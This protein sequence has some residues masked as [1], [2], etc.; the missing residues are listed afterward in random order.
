MG[1]W[2]ALCSVA[3]IGL[4]EAWASQTPTPPPVPLPPGV[5]MRLEVKD[6]KTT[7]KMGEPIDLEL[8]ISGDNQGYEV[9]AWDGDHIVL[10]PEANV[11]RWQGLF[12]SDAV[13]ASALTAQGTTFT[14]RLNDQF[15]IKDPGTYTALVHTWRVMKKPETPTGMLQSME[16][17][18]NTVTF[19]VLP[20]SEADEA[21]RVKMLAAQIEAAA[22]PE[23]AKKAWDEL[24]YLTGDA[25]AHEKVRLALAARNGELAEFPAPDQ[26]KSRIGNEDM[27]FAL[28]KNKQLEIELLHA[29]WLDARNV[30]DQGLL[31]SMTA[32]ARLDA[33]IGMPDTCG[34]CAMPRTKWDDTQALEKP[35]IDE[36]VASM[37]QRTGENRKET[38]LFLYQKLSRSPAS[39]GFEEARRIVIENFENYSVDEQQALMEFDIWQPNNPASLYDPSLIPVLVRIFKTA[40][41][42]EQDTDGI[43]SERHQRA[44]IRL[45]EIAPEVAV[46]YFVEE[47]KDPDAE[48]DLRQFGGLKETTLPQ[49]D[50]VLLGQIQTFAAEA[51]KEPGTNVKANREV[52]QAQTSLQDRTLLAAR[53][54]SSSI[55]AP[56]LELYRQYSAKWDS[57]QRGAVL[58]FLLRWDAAKT[59]PLLR[60]AVAPDDPPYSGTVAT[61][62]QV[63]SY[64][65]KPFPPEL[66][67]DLVEKVAHGSYEEVVSAAIQ[68][69]LHGLPEDEA[70]LKKRLAAIQAELK[71]HPERLDDSPN[72]GNA[73]GLV[74][75]ESALIGALR[76]DQVWHPTESDLIGLKQD[77]LGAFCRQLTT[78]KAQPA[79]PGY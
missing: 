23:V 64:I 34:M 78:D 52:S 58:A 79:P 48:L 31:Y 42:D 72:W 6:G 65:S 54:A 51:A 10:E 37:P 1:I 11:F 8:T 25:A 16:I 49:L 38:G 63:Y 56:M 43:N 66:R 41:P 27:A 39:A 33:G 13:Q 12:A 59:M 68:L 26:E 47:M 7:F 32:L 29:A 74:G 3:A 36:I 71:L 14:S 76:T 4:G 67:A 44:L 21:A 17:V 18:S 20:A 5:Y 53:Y 46:P 9:G 40:D 57:E 45:A 61:I 75:A 24:A 55:F 60:T 22:T 69:S 73:M 2:L 19:E 30:P 15:E 70:V 62:G 50:K 28:S 77:C 35:Y